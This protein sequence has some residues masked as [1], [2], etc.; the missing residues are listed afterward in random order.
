[1][2]TRPSHSPF[3][4]HQ[5]EVRAGSLPGFPT[6]AVTSMR[7]S[8]GSCSTYSQIPD[9]P[10][11]GAKPSRIAGRGGAE[12]KA[13]PPQRAPRARGAVAG[14]EAVAHRGQVRVEDERVPREEATRRE[15]RRDTLEDAPPVAPGREVE[16]RA[17]RAVDERRRLVQPQLAHV[18]LAQVELDALLRRALACD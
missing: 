7:P 18:R 10:W 1:M 2:S 9:S 15:G 6:Y 13:V 4:T 5:S 3:D 14:R 11:R 12:A 17:V 8:V 16:Q